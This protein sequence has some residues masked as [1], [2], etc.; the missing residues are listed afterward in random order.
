MNPQIFNEYRPYY[1]SEINAAMRRIADSPYFSALAAYVYPTRTPEE[2]RKQ[3]CAYTTI[4]EFQSQVMKAVSEQVIQRSIAH[5]SYAGVE[6]LDT[7]KSYMFVANHRDIMLD[8]TLL[9]YVLHMEGHQA[10]EITFGS[11]L[12][13]PQEAIDIGK[14][15]KMFKIVRSGTGR[16]IFINSL[17]VSEYMRYTITEKHQSTWIAQRNGR[18]KDG[19]DKTELAV[20][21]MFAMSSKKPFVENLNELNI[22]PIT[23]SYEYE[24]CDF[25]KTREMYFSRRGHYQKAPGEDLNSILHGI[26]QFKGNTHYTICKTITTEELEECAKLPQSEQFKELATIID[27]RIYAGY[28]LWKTNYIAHDMLYKK[29]EFTEL[30]NSN[31]REKFMEYMTGGLQK[32]DGD[33]SELQEIFL[34]IYANPV[35]KI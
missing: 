9:Q 7:N 15:N 33:M 29:S 14:S 27:K 17:N 35:D 21:K 24:P 2:V 8:A 11:N 4:D 10:S 18:T 34:E 6:N 1:D 20:L 12:M 16:E 28:K 25:M 13:H 26:L 31:D 5:F 19:S 32:I 3:I 22:T 30:Y 23:V